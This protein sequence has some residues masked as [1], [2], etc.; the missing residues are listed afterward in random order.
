M[1]NRQVLIN[2]LREMQFNIRAVFQLAPKSDGISLEE[3]FYDWLRD[4]ST[5]TAEDGPG[6]FACNTPQELQEIGNTLHLF[7]E[8]VADQITEGQTVDGCHTR[9]TGLRIERE[10]I[11]RK[12]HRITINQEKEEA[13]LNIESK[14]RCELIK[15][16]QTRLR[17][18]EKRTTICLRLAK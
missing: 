14:S 2:I 17:T 11:E 16:L 3:S 4:R 13:F 15:D 8:V 1:D 7:A 18:A 12:L 10:Q 6:M 9:L 5:G